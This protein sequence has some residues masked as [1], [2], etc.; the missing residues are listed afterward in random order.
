M[1]ISIEVRAELLKSVGSIARRMPEVLPH[2]KGA[3]RWL[4]FYEP[5]RAGLAVKTVDYYRSALEGLIRDLYNHNIEFDFLDK[6]AGLASSQIN[7]AVSFAW[8][9]SGI[10]GDLPAY[11][12]Q[13]AI[14]MFANEYEF[15]TRLYNDV[16]EARDNDE[17]IDA[18]LARADLWA[19]RFNDAYNAA[20]SLIAEHMGTKLRWEFGDTEHCETCLHL[21]GIVTYANVWNDCHVH[22]QAPPNDKLECGGWRCQCRLVQTDDRATPSARDRILGIVYSAVGTK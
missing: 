16:L 4:T 11:L 13:M 10:G 9:D 12:G 1:N 6:L 3:A 17:P 21:N 19:N 5:P 8:E 15:A 22:P 7:E 2:L 14:G 18:L 20:V